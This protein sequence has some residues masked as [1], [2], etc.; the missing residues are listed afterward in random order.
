[1]VQD[2]DDLEVVVVRERD[3]H[4]AGTEARVDPALDCLDPERVGDPLRRGQKAV[5]F[6]G[7]RNVVHTHGSHGA[8]L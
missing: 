3:D 5:G 4:V 6:A 7:I 8:T 2:L 1:V